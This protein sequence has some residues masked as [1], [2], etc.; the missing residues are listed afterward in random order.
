MYREQGAIIKTW[1]EQK[2]LYSP[3]KSKFVLNVFT[4]KFI[5]EYS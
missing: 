4:Y 2:E 3:S 1:C 5:V